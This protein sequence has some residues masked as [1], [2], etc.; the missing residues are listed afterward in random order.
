MNKSELI[1]QVA[2]KSDLTKVKATEAVNAV[3]ETISKEL[4]DGN[5]VSISG[6]GH[7]GTKIRKARVGRNP[8]KPTEEIKIPEKTV[9][10]F[11]AGA[12]LKNLVK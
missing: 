6:F 1:H 9:P 10:Y 7:F 12:T 8:Q 3:L 11:K 2:V 4:E 5:K